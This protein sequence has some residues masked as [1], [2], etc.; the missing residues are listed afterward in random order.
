MTKLLG[1]MRHNRA[2]RRPFGRTGRNAL[3]GAAFGLSSPPS[4]HLASSVS[5]EF[6]AYRGAFVEAR[7]PDTKRLPSRRY[8]RGRSAALVIP[9][10]GVTPILLER[11]PSSPSHKLDCTEVRSQ[12]LSRVRV[13]PNACASR[14]GPLVSFGRSRGLCSSTPRAAAISSIPS[15]GS[16]ARNKTPPPLPSRK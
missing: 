8:R 1:G 6:P 11:N 5:R 10:R 16:S 13:I 2:T 7:R 9:I 12:P 15:K 3:T 4:L 14:P